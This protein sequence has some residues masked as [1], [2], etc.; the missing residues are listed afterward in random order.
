MS[1]SGFLFKFGEYD[2]K[3]M[4]SA[5][6]YDVTPNARQDLDSYRDA[7]GL[8]HRNALDHTA[9][10]I[11]FT[12]RAHSEQEHEEMMAAIRANYINP[13][14]RDGNCTYYDPEYCGYKTGHFYIDSN[15]SFHIY[16]TYDGIMY[17]AKEFSVVEY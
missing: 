9:T 8:L 3:R 16:G 10:S 7:N 6:S 5:D 15:L 4:I 14:E 11:T 2:F 13:N 1:Y 17:G 12:I